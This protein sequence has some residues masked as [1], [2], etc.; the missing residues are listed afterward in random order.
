MAVVVPARRVLWSRSVG[1]AP[2]DAEGAA[3]PGSPALR[4]EGPVLRAAEPGGGQTL[5]EF[6][7]DGPIAAAPALGHRSVFFGTAGR[8]FY[9]LNAAT[10]KVR[11]RRRLQGAPAH[12]AVVAAGR[13]AVAASNSVVYRLSRRGGSILS[14]QAVPSRVI[15]EL[16]VAGPLV[17]ISSASPTVAALDMRTGKTAGQYE[18]PGS[19]V[20]GAVWTPPYVVLF[21]EDEETG[22]QKIIFPRS[23]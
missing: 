11:W 22:R 13:L 7:A 16:A 17:L 9:A 5:W 20:A 2:P 10:G 4:V 15:H 6:T 23:R 21:T 8:M 3:D 12:P 1:E 19:L 18:A 14:W